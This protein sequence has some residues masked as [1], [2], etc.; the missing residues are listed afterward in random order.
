MG[1]T[2]YD[3]NVGD[4]VGVVCSEVVDAKAIRRGRR[5]KGEREMTL[6]DLESLWR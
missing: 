6:N 2:W 3:S 5:K 4:V 1:P